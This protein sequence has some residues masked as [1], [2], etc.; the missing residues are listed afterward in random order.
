MT[1]RPVTGN[2]RSG[3]YSQPALTHV[4]VEQRRLQAVEDAFAS[5]PERYLGAHPGFHASYRIELDDLGLSWAVELDDDHCL[6]TVS[7]ERDP[8]VVIGTDAETWLELREG[9]LSGLDAFR[10]RRLWARGNLDLAVAFEGFFKLPNGRPP[11]LRIH[12]VKAGKARIS[13]LSAGDGIETVILIHGLGSDKTSFYET[14]SA[15]TPEYTVH[16]IDLPG[17]GSSSK[18]LRAPYDAAWFARAV[19]RFMDAQGIERAHLVGNSLGGRVAIEV[20]LRVPARVQSLSLLCP[21]LAWRKRRHFV[22]VVRLLRPELAAIP[23]NFGDALVRKQFWSM[24]ARPERIHP[25]AADVAVEEFLRNYRSANARI[26]FHAAARHIYLEE[27]NGPTGFW[28]RLRELEP[29]AMFVWGDEDPLVPLAFSRYVRDALPDVRQVVL[30]QCG[31][32]PQVEHP[33]DANALVHDFIGHARASAAERA[34]KRFG[35]AARRLQTRINGAGANGNGRSRAA[36]AAEAAEA[37][38]AA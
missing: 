10:S 28:T 12:E 5:L 17:F 7:P 34:A 26:A 38:D 16:A 22:P 21:S 18:P 14:V 4:P 2:S 20:G 19:C 37:A 27:P 8:D 30:D 3:R 35:R 9:K 31:H 36:E 25:N 33:V 11:L 24:F 29:P 1:S 23:H 6:V 15:L 13:T 32:V